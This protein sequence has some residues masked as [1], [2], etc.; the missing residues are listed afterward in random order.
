M[1]GNAGGLGGRDSWP[2]AVWCGLCGSPVC[3]PASTQTSSPFSS[4]E[5][6]GWPNRARE[7]A[8]E[9]SG[10][11][12]AGQGSETHESCLRHPRRRCRIGAHG[13][14]VP[15]PATGIAEAHFRQRPKVSAFFDS[16]KPKANTAA[17][18]PA[19]LTW[20][21][22]ASRRAARVAG[23]MQASSGPCFSR[24][25]SFLRHASRCSG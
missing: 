16:L 6:S 19:R 4:G 24:E 21:A 12:R 18:Q 8:I 11:V 3:L 1:R 9:S 17:R 23:T 13:P 5:R 25:F 10:P 22:L 2:A 20:H 15:G 7:L 14:L